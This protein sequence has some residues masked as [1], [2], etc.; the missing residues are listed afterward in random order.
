MF[1]PVFNHNMFRFLNE[2]RFNEKGSKLKIFSFAET[3]LKIKIVSFTLAIFE[4]LIGIILTLPIPVYKEI[5]QIL[6]NNL[7]GL[8]HLSGMYIRAI[9]YRRKLG[10]M[11]PNVFI[12][13]NV[14][15]AFPKNYFLHEFSY[16]D[17]NV[18]IMSKSCSVGRRT[19]ICPNAFISGGGDFEIESYACLCAGSI[20]LTSTEVISDGARCC[21]PMVTPSQRNVLRS[22]VKICKDAF[23]GVSCTILPGVTIAEGSVVAAGSTVTESTLPWSMNLSPNKAKK[24]GSRDQVTHEDD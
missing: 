18:L 16:I 10:L 9:Y 14:T 5:I 1:K 19:H 13:Q 2:S 3:V 11:E 23:V 8:P 4:F 20:V 21:G 24:F 15:F 6:I 22:R 7:P 17:K 12:D